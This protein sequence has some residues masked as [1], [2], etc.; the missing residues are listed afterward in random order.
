MWENFKKTIINKLGISIE[1]RK[2]LSLAFPIIGSYLLHTAYNLTDMIWVGRISSSAV[3]AV[4]S[5]GFF[6]SLGW[7]LSS[8]ITVGANVKIS[9][10]VGAKN[11]IEAGRYATSGAWGIG[12]LAIIIS[13]LCYL[14]LV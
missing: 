2:L 13:I 1:T 14:I 9:H 6:L 4:G 5:A 12:A 11:K 7:A 10:S 3:A 8:I